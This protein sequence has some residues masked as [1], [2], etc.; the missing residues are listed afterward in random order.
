M[1]E[2]CSGLARVTEMPAA[3]W[4]LLNFGEPGS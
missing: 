3:P 4:P 2:L 1:P